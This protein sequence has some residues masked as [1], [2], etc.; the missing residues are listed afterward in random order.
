LTR[1]ADHLPRKYLGH[2]DGHG[3]TWSHLELYLYLYLYL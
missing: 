1:L 3:L 2:H